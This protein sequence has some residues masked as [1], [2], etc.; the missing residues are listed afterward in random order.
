MRLVLLEYLRMLRESGEFD[1]LLPDL[2]LAMNIVPVSKAQ[3]GV[4]QSGVDLAAVGDDEDGAKTLWLF[5]LKRGDLGRRDWDSTPQAVRQSLDEIKDVYLSN[6]VAPEHKALLIKIVV[7][8]T[9]DFKQ[10]FEQQRVGYAARNAEPGRAYEFWNGDRVAALLEEHL[11][12][13]YVVPPMARSELRR[14]LALIGEPDY[15]LN[16]YHALLD[17]LLAPHADREVKGKSGFDYRRALSS[18]AL[19]LGVV[20]RWA[21]EAGNLKNALLACERTLLRGWDALRR[22]GLTSTPAAVA[23]YARVVRIYHDVSIEYLNKVHGHF[24]VED[25]FAGYCSE[26]ALLTEQVFEQI[27]IAAAI[28]LSHFFWGTLTE[29][30]RRVES[31][32]AV[33][34]V[35]AGLLRTHRI[36]GSPCYDAQIVDIVLALML[37]TATDRIDTAKSWLGELAGRLSF[38]FRLGRWFPLSTD[39]FDDLVETEIHPT[40]IAF[41]KLTETSWMVPILAQWMAVIGKDDAYKQLAGLARDTLQ[42]THF[43]IWYPDDGT[44]ALMYVGPAHWESGTTEAPVELPPTGEE[45]RKAIRRT[46]ADA[47]VKALQSSASAVGLVW[48]DFIASRH[49]RTPVDPLW[50]QSHVPE[51]DTGSD[52]V[53][54]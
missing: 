33:A 1:A 31:A 34:D 44:E 27:G 17:L 9:G 2:L 54:V 22:E 47:P 26:A 24:N 43:Q 32:H 28:G 5:V 48:L 7:A 6:H 19:S 51:P 23:A 29:D 18:T 10:D 35:L 52:K 16:H 8:T 40:E 41:Q 30:K 20:C 12:N 53:A 4:R 3:I 13:E 45:M 11:L 36:S 46:R 50:W 38:G 37:F 39:S 42:H 15:D 21:A 49:F 14:T 25:A